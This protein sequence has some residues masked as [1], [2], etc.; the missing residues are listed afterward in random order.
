VDPWTK[1]LDGIAGDACV[2]TALVK[3]YSC[4][5][6]QAPPAPLDSG[7]RQRRGEGYSKRLGPEE[8]QDHSGREPLLDKAY[9]RRAGAAYSI[10][11][12]AQRCLPAGHQELGE[13]PILSASGKATA[14][15]DQSGLSNGVSSES[16]TACSLCRIAASQ[17]GEETV[18]EPLTAG[19]EHEL[20]HKAENCWRRLYAFA[21]SI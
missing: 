5:A 16:T 12:G 7:A 1:T 15:P 4:P 19:P 13:R 18:R 21:C 2:R 3:Q 6:R 20:A 17:L 10:K 14:R 9:S 11:R 8:E